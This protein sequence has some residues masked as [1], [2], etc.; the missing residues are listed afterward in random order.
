MSRPRSACMKFKSSCRKDGCFSVG[1]R[2]EKSPC[3]AFHIFILEQVMASKNIFHYFSFFVNPLF[4]G[5]FVHS[6][7]SLFSIIRYYCSQNVPKKN[8][9]LDVQKLRNCLVC[10]QVDPYRSASFF[11]RFFGFRGVHKLTPCPNSCT[12]YPKNTSHI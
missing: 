11:V 9:S 8:L 6:Y 10:V 5:V 4:M 1:S 2:Y 12:L 3:R 7:F